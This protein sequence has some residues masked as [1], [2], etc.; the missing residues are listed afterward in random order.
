MI[1]VDP[2]QRNYS[3]ILYEGINTPDIG[4]DWF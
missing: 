1:A 3:I 2:F 4:T